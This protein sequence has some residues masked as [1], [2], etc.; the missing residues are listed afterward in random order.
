MY[1]RCQWL[2]KISTAEAVCSQQYE[3]IDVSAIVLEPAGWPVAVGN[4]FFTESVY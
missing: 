4:F 3:P 2:T 1:F